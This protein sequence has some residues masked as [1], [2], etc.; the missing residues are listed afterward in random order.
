MF[1]ELESPIGRLRVYASPDALLAIDFDDGE[2]ACPTASPAA[3]RQRL[4]DRA[5]DQLR[6]YFDGQVRSF[7]LPLAPVGTPFQR[8]AWGVLAEIPYAQTLSYAEQAR[9]LGRPRAVRAVGAA[10]ARNPLPIVLPC[11]RVIGADGRLV[12][13]GG[14]LERK[15]WLLEHEA[16]CT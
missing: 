7:D 13:Y 8:A 10:N 5:I 11:H 1:R 14:G 16:R 9:R 15:R 2:H 6:G 4:L 3:T 12:G